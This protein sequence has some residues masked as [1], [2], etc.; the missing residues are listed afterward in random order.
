MCPGNVPWQGA[1]ASLFARMVRTLPRRGAA[2][3][4]ERRSWIGQTRHFG[5]PLRNRDALSTLEGFAGQRGAAFRP[6]RPKSDRV[7]TFFD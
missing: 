6:A 2:A 5:G 1:G 3:S 7:T 4:G